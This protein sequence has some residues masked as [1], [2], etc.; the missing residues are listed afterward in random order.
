M[1]Y[2]VLNGCK[3]AQC[4]Y[5]ASPPKH[6]LKTRERVFISHIFL[7]K[8]SV[9][10]RSFH[11]FLARNAQPSSFEIYQEVMREG[12]DG[13]RIAKRKAAEQRPYKALVHDAIR[14]KYAKRWAKAVKTSQVK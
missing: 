10:G 11:E 6:T 9:M 14:Q 3:K 12:M 2:S 1:Q 5:F 4:A 13:R 7:P 8:S